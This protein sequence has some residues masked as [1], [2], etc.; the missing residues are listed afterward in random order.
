[1]VLPDVSIIILNWNGWIDTI[2]CLE[3]LNQIDYPNYNVIVVDNNSKDESIDMIEDFAKGQKNLIFIKNDK[4][5]GFAEGNNIGIRFALN[6]LRSDYILLLNND[7]LVK[8][9]FLNELIEVG[10]FNKDIMILGPKVYPCRNNDVLKDSA[11]VGSEIVFWIGALTKGIKS[12]NDIKDVELVSGACML[13]KN[14][15]FKKVGLLD[16]TYFFGWEDADFCTNTRK[17][18]Y[19]I[20]GVPKAKIFHKIGASYGSNFAE[21]PDILIEGIRNQLIFMDRHAS[22][23]QKMVSI[24]TILIYYFFIIFWKNKNINKIKSRSKSIKKGIKLFFDYKKSLN[25]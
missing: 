17:L 25:R 9:N 14:T 3:S 15:L 6:D 10:E 23:P 1:M 8:T 16:S 20:V 13:I 24:P 12:S 19:K 7:T 2:D 18:G 4:N 11:I 21:N 5:Y 22:I